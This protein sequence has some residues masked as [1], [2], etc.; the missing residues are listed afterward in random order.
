M[1]TSKTSTLALMVVV[2]IM[3]LFAGSNQVSAG[4]EGDVQ[5]LKAECKSFVSKLGPKRPPSKEC[6]AVVMRADVPCVCTYVTRAV[7]LIIS[8]NKAVYVART[9]GLQVPSGMQC[10][11]YIVPQLA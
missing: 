7:E 2:G 9:C 8:M 10:G 3:I 5:D 6:C 4:C 11:S 1:A